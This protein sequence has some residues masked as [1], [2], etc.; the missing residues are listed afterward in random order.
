MGG[1]DTTDPPAYPSQL[2]CLVGV[3]KVPPHILP[4]GSDTAWGL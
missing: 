3:S 1:S 4:A 2:E